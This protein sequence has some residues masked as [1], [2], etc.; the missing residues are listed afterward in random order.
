LEIKSFERPT[1]P[2]LKILNPFFKSSQL[3][4]RDT[5]NQVSV[6]IRSIFVAD[7]WLEMDFGVLGYAP[8]ETRHPVK[9]LPELRAVGLGQGGENYRYEIIFHTSK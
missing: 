7:V 6:A 5:Q 9:Q 4:G 3:I 2:G 8:D 1:F